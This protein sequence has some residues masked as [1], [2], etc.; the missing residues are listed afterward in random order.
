VNDVSAKNQPAQASS[1]RIAQ[2]WSE[3]MF[4]KKLLKRRPISLKIAKLVYANTLSDFE[5]AAKFDNSEKTIE[6]QCPSCDDVFNF[7]IDSK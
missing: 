7:K 1:I 6:V 5:I 2:A 4:A 3:W